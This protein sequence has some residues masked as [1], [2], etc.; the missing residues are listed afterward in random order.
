MSPIPPLGTTWSA[1]RT[2]LGAPF[3]DWS[4]DTSVHSK[5]DALAVRFHRQYAGFKLHAVEAL[6]PE[7]LN[8]SVQGE[9]DLDVSCGVDE[10]LAGV[11]RI[12]LDG[13]RRERISIDL[14]D[15]GPGIS[16][17][18]LQNRTDGPASLILSAGTLCSERGSRTAVDDGCD[19]DRCGTRQ[20]SSLERGASAPHLRWR[21]RCLWHRRHGI[22]GGLDSDGAGGTAGTRNERVLLG[23]RCRLRCL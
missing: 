10:R 13:K 17:V 5:G 4:F 7:S 14:R 18:V 1:T 6:T 12:A 9:V 15:C 21:V 23:V 3:R 8:L 11:G 2:V 16:D 19:T 20:G 22:A